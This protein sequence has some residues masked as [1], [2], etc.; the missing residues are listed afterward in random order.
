MKIEF[1]LEE[2]AT[3]VNGIDGGCHVCITTFLGNIPFGKASLLADYMNLT[4]KDGE[5]N[6]IYCKKWECWE[7]DY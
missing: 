2:L 1:G 7:A 5:Y 3:A 6:Y 4:K